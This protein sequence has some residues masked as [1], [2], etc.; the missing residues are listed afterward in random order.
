MIEPVTFSRKNTNLHP[1]TFAR[2]N[3]ELG[4]PS[5]LHV[6]LQDDDFLHSLL[7]QH[8]QE[9]LEE[10]GS[11]ENVRVRLN[12]CD[13]LISDYRNPRLQCFK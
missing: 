9:S 13:L 2:K 4:K 1:Q 8:E 11:D 10:V 3:I 12:L 5:L 7:P 6:L